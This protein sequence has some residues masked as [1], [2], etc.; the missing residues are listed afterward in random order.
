MRT[1]GVTVGDVVAAQQDGDFSYRPITIHGRQQETVTLQVTLTDTRTGRP[2]ALDI[3]YTL[4]AEDT[5]ITATFVVG[6]LRLEKA[7]PFGP[8]RRRL[9][10]HGGGA[11]LGAPARCGLDPQSR[12]APV[13]GYHL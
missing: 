9:P 5:Q 12:P 8:A 1:T 2:Y 4:T 3:P 7:V 13:P 10:P 6:R 11:C